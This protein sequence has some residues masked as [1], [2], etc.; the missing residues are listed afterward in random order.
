MNTKFIAVLLVISSVFVGCKEEKKETAPKQN[1]VSKSFVFSVNVSSPKDDT[2]S[3]YYTVDGSTDF[4][5]APIWVEVKGSESP[6]EVVFKLPEDAVPTQFRLDVCKPEKQNELKINGFKMSYLG[7]EFSVP[8]KDFFIYFDPDLSKTV[9]NK[10]TGEVK[11]VEKDGKKEYP[12]F[13]PNT[14]PLGDEINKL[15]K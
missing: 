14:R 8:G 9:Y 12:S 2:F 1:E 11:A 13:Y 6:Q 3:L 15:L 10:E 7:K 4:K 5:D